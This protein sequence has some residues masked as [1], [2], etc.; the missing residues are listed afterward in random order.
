MK[1]LYRIMVGKNSRG[2]HSFAGMSTA[3]KPSNLFKPQIHS[4][5]QNP[6]FRCDLAQQQLYYIPKRPQGDLGFPSVDFLLFD[7][8]IEPPRKE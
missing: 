6:R 7:A 1:D 5:L 2:Y 3:K 4:L 8:L